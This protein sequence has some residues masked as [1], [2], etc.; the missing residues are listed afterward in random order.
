MRRPPQPDVALCNWPGQCSVR[1]A[2]TRCQRSGAMTLRLSGRDLGMDRAPEKSSGILRRDGAARLVGAVGF[3]FGARHH[4]RRRPP[5]GP[6]GELLDPGH[7]R[8]D[9]PRAASQKESRLLMGA[10]MLPDKVFAIV[11]AVA[12]AAPSGVLVLEAGWLPFVVSQLLRALA[13][14]FFWTGTQFAVRTRRPGT[15]SAELGRLWAWWSPS[16]RAQVAGSAIAERPR[17]GGLRAGRSS[18]R[19]WPAAW[20]AVGP[21]AGMAVLSG[22]VLLVS[23]TEPAPCRPW[24][25]PSPP[26]PPIPRRGSRSLRPARPAPQGSWYRRSAVADPITAVPLRRRPHCQLLITVPATGVSRLRPA[27]A[28]QRARA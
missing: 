13:E 17:G 25:L 8:A 14:A 27:P 21:F 3:A 4:E 7:R 5:G 28:G 26:T 16:Q 22:V 18:W 23:G 1:A 20:A 2:I 9:R 11:A 12:L 24:D 6:V 19:L 15:R 10:M